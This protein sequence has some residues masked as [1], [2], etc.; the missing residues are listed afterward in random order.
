M[1]F[2]GF[3]APLAAIA[4]LAATFMIATTARAA[5]PQQQSSVD[6]QQYIFAASNPGDAANVWFPQSDDPSTAVWTAPAR[7]PQAAAPPATLL[8]RERPL[9]PLPAAAWTGLMGL[10]CLALFIGRKALLRFV[11]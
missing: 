10:G 3:K 9:I 7:G 6:P 8:P 5:E 1:K 2:G 4:L 11:S